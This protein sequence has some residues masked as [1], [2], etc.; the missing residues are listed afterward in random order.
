MDMS[1]EDAGP[2]FP[3]TREREAEKTIAKGMA[4]EPAKRHIKGVMSKTDGIFSKLE[5]TSKAVVAKTDKNEPINA[6]LTSPK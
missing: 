3:G 2:F 4:Q 1:N 5:K 6:D